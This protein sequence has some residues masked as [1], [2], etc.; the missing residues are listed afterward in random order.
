MSLV[1][2]CL[3]LGTKPSSQNEIPQSS[4][5][6][7]A[8]PAH[9]FKTKVRSAISA[10]GNFWNCTKSI[11]T[12]EVKSFHM[13]YTLDPIMPNSWQ[14]PT[15]SGWSNFNQDLFGFYIKLPI[16]YEGW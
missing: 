12:H 10:E 16:K 6:T 7:I 9:A 15:L 1:Q 8:S 4:A 14:T 3:Q 5:T 11:S 13:P 2:V